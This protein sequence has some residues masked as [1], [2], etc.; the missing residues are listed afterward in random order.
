MPTPIRRFTK[1]AI[2]FAQQLQKLRSR[3]LV[4]LDEPRALRYLANISYYRLSG[5]WGSFLTPATNNFLPGT[6]LDDILHRYQF[7][8]Q[9][10]LLCLEAI[11]RLE[12]S[13]RTQI[14]YHITRYTGDNNWYEKPRYFKRVF[15]IT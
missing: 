2:D 14:I 4:V 3:G 11:E 7:D 1:P 12:I 15:G 13:F 6:K 9:L 8:K 5:Y 10:R